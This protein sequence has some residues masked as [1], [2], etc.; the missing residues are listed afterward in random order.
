MNEFLKSSKKPPFIPL[1]LRRAYGNAGF[2]HL[3]DF[4]TINTMPPGQKGDNFLQYE[5]AKKVVKVFGLKSGYEWRNW[6]KLGKRPR[7]IPADPRSYYDNKGWI[8]WDDFLG[9]E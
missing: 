6:L 5:D 1:N 4:L 8:S 3:N 2:N 7:N 9:R